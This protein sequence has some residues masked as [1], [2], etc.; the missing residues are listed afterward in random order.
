ME[1]CLCPC[2]GVHLAGCVSL[3]EFCYG[4]EIIFIKYLIFNKTAVVNQEQFCPQGTFV[5]SGD[6]CDCHHLGG[7]GLLLA[8]NG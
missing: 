1:T 6:I 4:T 7:R 3:G 8:S 2:P 5:I